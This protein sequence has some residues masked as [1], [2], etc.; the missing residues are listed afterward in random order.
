MVGNL[1]VSNG[2]TNL[3]IQGAKGGGGGS[4]CVGNVML[5]SC[6]NVMADDCD[7]PLVDNILRAATVCNINWAAGG[8]GCCHSGNVLSGSNIGVVVSEP[9][10]EVTFT[11]NYI[12]SHTV[13]NVRLAKGGSTTVRK[14]GNN[15][16]GSGLR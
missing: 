15:K 10:A 14:I 3:K 13:A 16:F 12:Y 7:M 11:N 8:G 9:T 1:I 4:R 5:G 6:V 2:D